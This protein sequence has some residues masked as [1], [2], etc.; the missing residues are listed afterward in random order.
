MPDAQSF[1]EAFPLPPQ[2]SAAEELLYEWARWWWNDDKAPEKL[3][4]QLQVR[5]SV[6]FATAKERHVRLH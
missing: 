1:E 3:P 2:L 5:T 6:Y 4:D